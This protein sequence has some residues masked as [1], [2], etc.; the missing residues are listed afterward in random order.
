MTKIIYS[1]LWEKNIT[2]VSVNF[3]VSRPISAQFP[4]FILEHFYFTYLVSHLHYHHTKIVLLIFKLHSYHT[5]HRD[6]KKTN[7]QWLHF[8]QN[9]KCYRRHHACF[10]YSCLFIPI[11]YLTRLSYILF[12]SIPHD[13]QGGGKTPESLPV[14]LDNV[15]YE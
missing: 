5:L 12:H 7:K 8:V 2:I 1:F 4:T 3:V 14:S 6:C 13:I 9:F 11:Q 10:N 15:Q